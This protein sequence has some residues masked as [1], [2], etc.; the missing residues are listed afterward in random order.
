MLGTVLS[1][2]KSICWRLGAPGIAR[3]RAHSGREVSHLVDGIGR[4]KDLLGQLAQVDL[5][6]RCP[7]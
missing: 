4:I 7:L 6:E 3:S 2:L 5:L 1:A